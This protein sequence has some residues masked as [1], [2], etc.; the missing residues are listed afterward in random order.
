MILKKKAN[1]SRLV[2]DHRIFYRTSRIENDKY[3]LQN[4]RTDET[5]GSMH[6]AS[7]TIARTN[8]KDVFP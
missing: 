8:D 2:V 5:N 3:L 7:L 1:I 4:I 6:E